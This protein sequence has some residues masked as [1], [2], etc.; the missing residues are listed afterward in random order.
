MNYL[1]LDVNI[2]T[3]SKLYDE[4]MQFWL[5]DIPVLLSGEHNTMGALAAALLYNDFD[6]VTLNTTLGKVRG[7][8]VTVDGTRIRQFRGIPYAKSPTGHLRFRKPVPVSPWLG[9]L[10]ATRFGPTCMQSLDQNVLNSLPSPIMSEDCLQLNIFIPASVQRSER[11]SVMV[12]IHGGAYT[13][14]MASVYDGSFLADSGDVLVVTINY[15]VSVFGFLSTGNAA[16]PGNYGLWDQHEALKW[17]KQNIADYGGDPG[18]MTIF[19]ESA[20]G[21]SVTLQALSPHSKGLFHRVIAESGAAVGSVNKDPI[22]GAK[23]VSIHVGCMEDGQHVNWTNVVECLRHKNASEL[24]INFPSGIDMFEAEHR[25]TFKIPVGPVV[26]FDFL[27]DIPERLIINKTSESFAMFTS[28]DLLAGTMAADGGYGIGLLDQFQTMYNFNMTVGIPSRILCGLIAPTCVRDFLQDNPALSNA[29]CYMYR[30]S[31]PI[32]QR[33]LLFDL[34]G[35]M[36]FA[37]PTA[38]L[39]QA[40]ADSSVKTTYQFLFS[41]TPRFHYLYHPEWL[42]GP[43]H[44]DELPILF[45]AMTKLEYFR[46]RPEQDVAM[47]NEIAAYW[48]N[49]AKFG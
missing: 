24:N 4:R 21:T 34:L 40:H 8:E 1:N 30:R 33:R 39:L 6:T 25:L 11:K 5:N 2:S 32:E 43:T 36:F 23:Y 48:T 3:G 41:Y 42:H 19:G 14:G 16:L 15:R 7:V 49:F 47:S 18:S 46:N 45:P 31:D 35:D 9:T 37:A 29:I 28:V 13:H 17:V 44:A 12:W 20:G 27:P 10:D 38:R 26:D 22:L